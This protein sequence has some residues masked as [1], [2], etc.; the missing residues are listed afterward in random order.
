MRRRSR[1]EGQ[2]ERSKERERQTDIQRWYAKRSAAMQ[3]KTMR[4]QAKRSKHTYMQT[5]I[6]LSLSMLKRKAGHLLPFLCFFHALSL[7]LCLSLY[8]CLRK[9][10]ATCYPFLVS[11]F[12]FL[13]LSLS[14][15]L[16]LFLSLPTHAQEEAW[17][18]VI[19]SLG[20]SFLSLSLT[21]SLSL[22]L[23]LSLSPYSCSRKAWSPVTLSC[24]FLSFFS[25]SLSFSLSFSPLSLSLSPYPC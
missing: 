19:P 9:G 13:S 23:F 24:F 2:T 16:S 3:F 21:L 6:S 8:P 1:D 5:Y 7:C 12:L 11:F 18:P 14:L 20:S 10:L 15:S 22:S 25:L 4:W 17:P